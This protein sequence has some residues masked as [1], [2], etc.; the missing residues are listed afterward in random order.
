MGMPFVSSHL[1]LGRNPHRDSLDSFRQTSLL[2]HA[3]S[4]AGA[5][6]SSNPL[7]AKA[8]GSAWD[9]ALRAAEMLLQGSGGA[10]A[11][12]AGSRSRRGPAVE[13]NTKVE[14]VEFS[15]DDLIMELEA[16]EKDSKSSPAEWE[17]M[18]KEMKIDDHGEQRRA[19]SNGHEIR[20]SRRSSDSETRRRFSLTEGVSDEV[21]SERAAQWGYGVVLKN[22][23]ESTP[24]TSGSS[25]SMSSTGGS[26]G[27]APVIPGVSKDVKDA[28][29]SFQLAFLVCDATHHD[30]PILY[31]SAGFTT[32]TGYSADE[33]VGKNCRFLQGADTDR[34]EIAKVREVLKNGSIFTGTLLNY[35]KDGTPFWN[36]LTLSPIKDDDGK[37]IKY[38]GMQAEQPSGRTSKGQKSPAVRAM[39]APTALVQHVEKLAAVQAASTSAVNR[40]H[41]SNSLPRPP[42]A[43]QKASPAS[44]SAD[45]HNGGP[46]IR[47][48]EQQQGRTSHRYSLQSTPRRSSRNSSV[49]ECIEPDWREAA[50]TLRVGL[51]GGKTSSFFESPE[52]SARADPDIGHKSRSGR[53]TSRLVRLFRKDSKRHLE[54]VPSEK[55]ILDFSDSEDERDDPTNKSACS[56]GS[57]RH[58]SGAY[59]TTRNSGSYTRQEVSVERPRDNRG[60]PRQSSTSPPFDGDKQ[61]FCIVHT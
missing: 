11:A 61:Q 13:R 43:P 53:L 31:A 27:T 38:I 16:A 15:L 2:Q 55:E 60:R 37:V 22:S 54:T 36:L 52:T 5:A 4:S 51:E 18:L 23:R 30:Y 9:D 32:M 47:T 46:E 49:D 59:S 56:S 12:A 10:S 34:S 17:G 35:K 39:Q 40:R 41:S 50:L 21:I 33:I 58:S 28:L 26:G 24:R 20:Q 57:N 48:G 7:F 8:P 29:A 6:R 45:W 3:Y 44:R 1:E 14:P 25:G 19:H 42:V